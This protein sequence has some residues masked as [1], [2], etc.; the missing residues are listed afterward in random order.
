[1]SASTKYLE[2]F[3]EPEARLRELD[4]LRPHGPWAHAI[5]IPARREQSSACLR[6]VAAPATR[7]RVL[8]VLVVNAGEDA[9]D[10]RSNAAL[11]TELEARAPE[12]WRAPGLSLHRLDAP[13]LDVLLVDRSTPP[14]NFASRD[15]V[16]LARKLGADLIARLIADR[17]IA[18]PWIHTTDADV[19]LPAEH[20]E[21]VANLTPGAAVAPFRHV[22]AGD[23][24]TH[25]ATQRYELSLRYYVL[26]L[27][28]AGSPYA[29]QTI[30]SLISVAASSYAI[31]RGFPRRQA[32]EDFYML[33]KLAKLGP[34]HRLG[35][36]PV[37]IRSRRSSR[38]P[39]GTGPAV[40]AL[41][42]GK[43]HEVYDP[44]T[45]DVL[46][47]ALRSLASGCGLSSE[48]VREHPELTSWRDSA[49]QLKR[50][51]GPNQ[52]RVR[53][54]EHFDGFRTLKLIHA[55]TSRWPKLPWEGAIV[56][57]PFLDLASGHTLDWQCDQ[58]YALESVGC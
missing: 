30:G 38:A 36:E 31:A 2:R 32:G 20:F 56:R 44:R 4:G 28:S 24:A 43:P 7:A 15:G 22:E 49:D 18:S 3:A 55:L 12:C 35:G 58:L 16:G 54:R 23:A 39:F 33:N 21:R 48:L 25:A 52:L 45:F 27:R 17:L 57:A 9:D 8:V 13:E 41:L 19:E 50:R 5:A 40:E 6:A 14:R 1:M 46:G 42:A 11:L 37:Q 10:R 47:R 53:V 26:G 34:V 29:F 51:Y